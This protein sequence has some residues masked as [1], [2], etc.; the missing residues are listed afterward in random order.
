[1]I[2][3]PPPWEDLNEQEQA[4]LRVMGPLLMTLDELAARGAVD[5]EATLGALCA[6]H[7]VLPA[8]DRRSY[9]RLRRIPHATRG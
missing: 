9:L 8:H 1:M 3:P 2:L 4:L 5:V 7:W 6:K